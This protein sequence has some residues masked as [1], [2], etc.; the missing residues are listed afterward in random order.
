M[1]MSRTVISILLSGEELS[2]KEIAEKVSEISKEKIKIQAVSNLLTRL[3]DKEKCD[4]G[5]FIRKNKIR[6]MFAYKMIHE[7]LALSEEQAYGLYLKTGN[8]KY[9]L[10]E[11]VE[12]YPALNRFVN[13]DDLK[14]SVPKVEKKTLEPEPVEPEPAE[15]KRVKSTESPMPENSASDQIFEI[16]RKSP[17]GVD[18]ATLM[19]KTK[20]DDDKIFRILLRLGAQDKV[21]RAGKGKYKIS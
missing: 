17:E 14:N 3:N 16:I 19:K 20:L 1:S 18:I 11:A 7:A 9:T 5:H 8:E 2:L 21:V 15:P 6:G 10:R 12:E 13:P 4:L